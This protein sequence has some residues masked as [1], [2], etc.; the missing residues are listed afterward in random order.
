MYRLAPEARATGGT[1]WARRLWRSLPWLPCSPG[2]D[3]GQDPSKEDEDEQRLR[4]SGFEA[5]RDGPGRMT[6]TS[7]CVSPSTP[8]ASGPAWGPVGQG[9]V[10]PP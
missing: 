4:V 1:G 2:W 8:G 7:S 6:L 9:L 5:L 10:S 3:L